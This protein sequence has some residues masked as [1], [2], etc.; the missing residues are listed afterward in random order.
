MV[1]LYSAIAASFLMRLVFH[2]LCIHLTFIFKRRKYAKNKVKNKLHIRFAKD[3]NFTVRW[4]C[5]TVL[6]RCDLWNWESFMPL[7][8]TF[9]RVHFLKCYEILW[10]LWRKVSFGLYLKKAF[11]YK[12]WCVLRL[13][14]KRFVERY[15]NKRAQTHTT[16]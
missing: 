8:R 11:V 13:E 6:R 14:E 10:F 4:L 5:F 7:K 3:R 15:G 16:F 1:T 2:L 12:L 9:K